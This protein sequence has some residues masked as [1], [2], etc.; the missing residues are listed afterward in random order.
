MKTDIIKS[1]KRKIKDLSMSIGAI[2]IFN[3]VIQFAMYPFLE[4]NLGTKGYGVALSVLS[5]IS[6]LSGTLGT[7]AS[8]SRMVTC[9][10]KSIEYTNG[11]YNIILLVL[12]TLCG[13]GG[14]FYLNYI[15]V[16][17]IFSSLI[18][19]V[20]IIITSFRYYSDVEYKMNT[21]FFRYMLFYSIIS[22]GYIIGMLIYRIS[23]EWL[24]AFLIGESL[25]I[26][27]VVIWGT[28]Y[29]KN[30]L[31]PSKNFPLICKSMGLL[32]F[33]NLIENLTLN[34]DRILLMVFSGEEAVAI[35]Y[36]A[37]LLG[38]VVAMLSTPINSI[39]ISYLV[40]YEGGLTKKFWTISTLAI[41]ALGVLAFAGCTIV[42]PF[43]LR[44]LYPDLAPE[45]IPYIASAILGQIFYF[46][47]GILLVIL[48]KFRGEKKQFF[49]NVAYAVEFFAIVIA[50]TLLHGLDGFVYSSL[51]A[52]AIRFIA[53][54]I[55]GF[56][57][58]KSKKTK[59]S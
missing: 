35:Y 14:I 57:L 15:G 11:D 41:A 59:N 6:I 52:N 26:A 43:M 17:S 44:I 10:N 55:W 18:F 28:I 23:G 32:L 1:N 37:S 9:S 27:F 20:L 45:C 40:K 51:I 38:K 47:S 50:G 21:A 30:I 19:L 56:S 33:S 36:T 48:L 34:A 24:L 22:V 5:V 49:F 58:T 16:S 39:I 54:I 4:R 2:A 12:S 25:G 53:V 3:M 7:S 8:Y 46:I 13:I 31:T 29:R 42:S